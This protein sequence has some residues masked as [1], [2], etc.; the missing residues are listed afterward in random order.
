MDEELRNELKPQ[1]VVKFERV[2]GRKDG[3]LISADSYILP[4]QTQTNFCDI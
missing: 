1:G 3:Q 2:N 4:V